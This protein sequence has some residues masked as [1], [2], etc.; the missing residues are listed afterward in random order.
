[1]S[2][3]SNAF[4]VTVVLCDLAISMIRPMGRQIFIQG[5]MRS[6]LVENAGVGRK[7]S[8]QMPPP[9]G[10]ELCHANDVALPARG[11]GIHPSGLMATPMQ[12]Q[13]QATLP[14]VIGCRP[15]LAAIVLWL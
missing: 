13:Q 2:I 5:Q 6:E 12:D 9:D 3:A 8:V 10:I 14:V 1:M 15:A 11:E 7:D 4:F